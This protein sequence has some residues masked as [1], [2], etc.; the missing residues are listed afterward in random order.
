MDGH[1]GFPF[2]WPVCVPVIEIEFTGLGLQ[3]GMVMFAVGQN[4]RGTTITSK[5]LFFV[6]KSQKGEGNCQNLR[7]ETLTVR[8]EARNV[9]IR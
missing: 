3:F 1:L 6:K 8:A 7:E 5:T 4:I 2:H 9:L